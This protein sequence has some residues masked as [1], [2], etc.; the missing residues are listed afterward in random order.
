MDPRQKHLELVLSDVANQGGKLGIEVTDVAGR[1][2]QVSHRIRSQAEA[3]ALMRQNTEL[4]LQS[5]NKVAATAQQAQDVANRAQEQMGSS[6]D[7]LSRALEAIAALASVVDAI[8][9]DS[10]N[11]GQAVERV[12]KIA[13]NI[14]AIARQTNLLA[15]NATI[16]AARAGEA[17]R[18]FAVVASEVKALARHTSEATADIGKT[19]LALNNSVRSVI[20]R[21][22]VG[23][24]GAVEARERNAEVVRAV[25]EVGQGM[26]AL[27][28]EAR[29]IS[30]AAAEIDQHCRDVAEDIA[31]M[32]GAIETSS[33][34]L[35]NSR[36][37]LLDLV[38]ISQALIAATAEAGIET[39]DTPFIR[40][41]QE[42]ASRIAALFEAAIAKGDMTEE[43]LFAED[44]A[45]VPGTNP[46]QHVAKFVDFT[47]RHLPSIFEATMSFSSKIDICTA[48]DRNGFVPT[49]IPKF[50]QP[51]GKDRA[52]NE[53][54]SRNRRFFKD[55]VAIAA[56]KN[57]KP[58]LLQTL[59]RDAGA[60][61]FV[62]V[63]DIASPIIVRNRLWGNF[64][65]AYRD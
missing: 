41:A 61:N 42:D 45:P 27:Q 25:D 59:R 46:Q 2:A 34:D 16:E 37:R 3:F 53:A 33:G 24:T 6:R 12:G 62:A 40:R 58:F 39:V 30:S 47:D 38:T 29:S 7:L 8:H 65:M 10:R 63:K 50:S 14:D 9:E 54:K 52:S 35:E 18:G 26:L 4:M 64:R 21:A 5:N 48:I 55:R 17:G 36:D 32:S 28:Q 23:A 49:H 60:G 57:Q 15:L 44:Y 20:E 11:L 51:Q 22:I 1:V 31:Q 56:A 19:V 43:A 13:A